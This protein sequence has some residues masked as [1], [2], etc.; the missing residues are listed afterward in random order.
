M[1]SLNLPPSAAIVRPHAETTDSS[2]CRERRRANKVKCKTFTL[3]GGALVFL[4]GTLQIFL[5][6][7]D[8]PIA[9]VKDKY[10][11]LGDSIVKRVQNINNT[12]VI[13][14]PGST[15][16]KLRTLIAYGKVPEINDK[17]I[18]ILHIGTNDVMSSTPEDMALQTDQLVS[19]I[20]RIPDG[21][22]WCTIV[23]SQIIP[24]YKDH[25]TSSKLINEYHDLLQPL[26]KKWHFDVI[27]TEDVFLQDNLPIKDLY[28]T[29]DHLHPND[30][31]DQ[32]LRSHLSN[33]IAILRKDRRWKRTKHA[34]HDT[35]VR[36]SQANDFSVFQGRLGPHYH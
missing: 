2:K 3:P 35:I 4:K 19:A 10:L 20:R 6:N 16:A 13:S 7:F 31:G 18:I 29:T 11:I 28:N 34:P 30:E 1:M 33:Y 36:R 9:P 25:S 23:V 22:T 26:K 8:F 5:D 21:G 27:P 32:K 15:L 17:K 24:R 12:L 14:Y